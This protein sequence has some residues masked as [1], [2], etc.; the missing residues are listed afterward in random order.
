MYLLLNWIKNRYFIFIIIIITLYIIGLVVVNNI[1][2]IDYI[3]IT[4]ICFIELGNRNDIFIL[5]II[6]G[7]IMDL[8]YSPIVGVYLI[9]FF[10]FFIASEIYRNYVNF[11]KLNI[12][13]FFYLSIILVY[14]NF[15]LVVFRY[16][17]DTFLA[18]NINRLSLDISVCLL[19]FILI[20]RIQR[21]L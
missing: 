13:I 19:L 10:L 3:L 9:V 2:Y 18:I 14:I 6:T 17:L 8:L 12:R 1:L 11:E 7:L 15:S 16:P 21:A 5:S 4:Y 20:K